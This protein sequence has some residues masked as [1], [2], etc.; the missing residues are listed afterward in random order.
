MHPLLPQ[1]FLSEVFANIEQLLV[2]NTHVVQE[3]TEIHQTTKAFGAFFKKAA[4][5]F[6]MY[7]S[8]VSNYD[9][10]METLMYVEK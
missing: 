10:A 4:P 7:S 5:F 9:R 1:L 2:F 3:F 6:K 8:Y